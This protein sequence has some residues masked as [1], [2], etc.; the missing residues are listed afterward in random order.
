MAWIFVLNPPLLRPIAWS[1]PSF[2]GAGAVLMCAYDGAVDHRVF[3]VR[4]GRQHFEELLPYAALGPARKSGVNLDRVAKPFRQVPPRNAGAITIKNSFNKQPIIFGRNSD[5][6]LTPRQ[7]ILDP[8]P[9]IVPKGIA[10][11]LSAPNQLTSHESRRYTL[12]NRL[13][14]DRP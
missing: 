12:G 4:I 14:E 10:A 9:L 11:H 1:S 13:I 7:N 5:V 3:V 6:A 2:L 8:V